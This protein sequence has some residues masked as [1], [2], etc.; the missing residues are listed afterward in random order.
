MS[1]L[2]A[3]EHDDLFVRSR[4]ALLDALDALGEQR[5]CV[6]VTGAHAIYMHTAGAAVALA[7]ATKDSD[8]AIDP[9]RLN[10]SPLIEEAMTRGGFELDAVKHQPGAWLNKEG[11]PVDLMVPEHLAGKGSKNARSAHLPPHDKRTFR[12]ARGL[13]IAELRAKLTDIDSAIAHNDYRIAN[14]RAGYVYVISNIGAFGAGIVKIGLTR[15]LEPADRVRELGGASVPFRYDTHAL[16]FSDDAVSLESELHKAFAHRRVNWVNER[17]EFFFATP[18]E[19]REVL[20]TKVGALLE[21]TANPPASKYFQSKP[22]W[23]PVSMQ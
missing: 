20:T 17:R 4:S 18:A 19:V 23:P 1:S 2:G 22:N 8:L 13:E 7:E 21:Y 10:E 14:I 3:F 11:I 16:F 15:R 12:R 5:D 6:V 9:R